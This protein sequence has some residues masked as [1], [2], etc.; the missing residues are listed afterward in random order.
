MARNDFGAMYLYCKL[1]SNRKGKNRD[2]TKGRLSILLRG[3]C[4]IN[5]QAV[6]LPVKNGSE[7]ENSH[8]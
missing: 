1:S 7:S 3:V 2:T 4:S 8:N 6:E 5:N